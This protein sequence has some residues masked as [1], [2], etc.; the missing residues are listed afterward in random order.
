MSNFKSFP[1]NGYFFSTRTSFKKKKK[2]K[3]KTQR[4]L[5][6]LRI[7]FGNFFPKKK[8]TRKKN[9]KVPF[10]ES[11]PRPNPKKSTA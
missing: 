2:K 3:K 4:I 8:F 10:L 7:D 6:N 5:K 9:K 11:N 1:K